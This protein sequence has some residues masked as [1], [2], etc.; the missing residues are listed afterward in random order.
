MWGNPTISGNFQRN[1]WIRKSG[2]RNHT[3]VEVKRWV[4][5]LSAKLTVA[6][7]VGNFHFSI[8][9]S[10]EISGK[11]NNFF[12]SQK[13]PSVSLHLVCLRM[14]DVTHAG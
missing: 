1:M 14:P 6:I 5:C 12:F 2:I 3:S 7:S 10:L 13:R 11:I 8:E 9:F 4:D